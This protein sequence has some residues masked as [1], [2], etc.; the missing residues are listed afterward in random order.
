MLNVEFL[1]L[2]AKKGKK[3]KSVGFAFTFRFQ[4]WG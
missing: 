2:N 1:M 4:T 3:A